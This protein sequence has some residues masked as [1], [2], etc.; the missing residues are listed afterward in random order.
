MK[1]LQLIAIILWTSL[2]HSESFS[3]LPTCAS[4]CINSICGKEPAQE[5]YCACY[6]NPADARECL[7]ACN[8]NDRASAQTVLTNICSTYSF[9][10]PTLM[11]DPSVMASLSSVHATATKLGGEPTSS[12]SKQSAATGKSSEVVWGV[13][14]LAL[15]VS[16]AIVIGVIV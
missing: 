15:T 10:G 9:D 6:Q 2:V 16:F 12:G 11:L 13:V 14:S 5:L 3:S 4:N 8:S 1:F 7:G